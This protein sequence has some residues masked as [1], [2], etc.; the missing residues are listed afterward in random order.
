VYVRIPEAR[1]EFCLHS[2]GPVTGQAMLLRADENMPG[3]C[4]GGFGLFCAEFMKRPEPEG[5]G[6][7]TLPSRLR[8]PVL[9]ARQ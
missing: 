3:L 2:R 5:V 4:D 1:G 6:Y 7:E 9:L 8:K